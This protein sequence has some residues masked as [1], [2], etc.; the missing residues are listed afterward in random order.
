MPQLPLG[1]I[2]LSL[3]CNSGENADRT[4]FTIRN[5]K[6]ASHRVMTTRE[7]GDITRGAMPD[8]LAVSPGAKAHSRY[9]NLPVR[10]L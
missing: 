4:H 6:I 8:L 2:I 3:P 7:E 9:L 10:Q 5:P 1:R